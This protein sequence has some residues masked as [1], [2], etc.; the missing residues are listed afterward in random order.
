MP[1]LCSRPIR[2]LLSTEVRFT[3]LKVWKIIPIFER[4][5]RSWRDL[6]SR[7][8]TP[9]IVMSPPLSGTRPLMTRMSVDF[10]APDRPTMTTIWPSGISSVTSLSACTPPG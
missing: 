7:T 3:R 5:S 2:T 8:L 4:I 10:P 6:A 9:S 1:V